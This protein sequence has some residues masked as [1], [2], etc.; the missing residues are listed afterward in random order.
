MRLRYV[1]VLKIFGMI[2]RAARSSRAP[3]L[4]LSDMLGMEALSP[5]AVLNNF[6]HLPKILSVGMRERTLSCF[7]GGSDIE[8]SCY[9]RSSFVQDVHSIMPVLYFCIL[10][11]T[12]VRG[13]HGM[14]SQ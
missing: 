2:I 6:S 11:T 14:R 4:S 7:G 5:L 9:N 10:S 12:L 1:L 3:D 8:M 13:S